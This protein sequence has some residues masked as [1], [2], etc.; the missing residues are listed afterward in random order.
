MQGRRIR[1]VGYAANQTG[2]HQEW[3][4]LMNIRTLP[5]PTGSLHLVE[6]EYAPARIVKIEIG[7]P[8]PD[9][10]AYDTERQQWYQRAIAIVYLHTQ[11]LGAVECMLP[12]CGLDAERCARRIWERLH[13]QINEHLRNDG[14]PPIDALSAAGI[15]TLGIPLCEQKREAFLASAPFVSVIV[16]THDRPDDLRRCLPSLLDLRYPHYEVII[17]DNAPTLAATADVVRAAQEQDG[18][19]RYVREDRAGPSWARNAGIAVASGEILAFTDDDV[20]VDPNWLLELVRGFDAP[21]NV[22][23]VTG[24]LQPLELETPAQ[25]WIEENAGL[26]WFQA[27][28]Q[29]EKRFIR[30]IFTKAQRHVHL[31]RIGLFGCGASMAFR[32][33]ALMRVSG[34]DPAMG[35]TGPSRCGQ[36]V[37]A[38]FAVLMQG[39]TIVYEPASVIYHRHRRS[40]AALSRQIYTYGIGMTAYLTKNV[41][42]HPELLLDLC[43][44]VP[45]DLLLKRSSEITVRPEDYPRELKRLALK[46][47]LYGPLAYVQSRR[48]AR[49]LGMHYPSLRERLN[50]VGTREAN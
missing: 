22:G 35:G 37:A 41:Y 9:I 18:C 17:V 2:Q 49:R 28:N 43:T 5:A 12:A 4:K 1:L 50:V 44:R 42:E 16:P 48:A 29:P 34:F 13:H 40:Y 21:N 45:F 20:E 39:Y 36:D 46:G 38:F 11:P 33:E 31:Y 7:G 6:T 19:V 30:R 27:H 23:C 3:K 15:T 24:M 26:F 25:Y 8:V 47:M 14:L 32:K 10:A